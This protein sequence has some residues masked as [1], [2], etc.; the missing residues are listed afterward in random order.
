MKKSFWQW[1]TTPV[2]CD[3]YYDYW[4]KKLKK[5]EEDFRKHL[6]QK[7]AI[8]NTYRM[9]KLTE[10]QYNELMARY[11]AVE[12]KGLLNSPLYRKIEREILEE[13]ALKKIINSDKI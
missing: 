3:S 9:G 13:E 5:C 10:E 2:G 12:T 6:P 1:L 11:E 8:K 7:H 4:D